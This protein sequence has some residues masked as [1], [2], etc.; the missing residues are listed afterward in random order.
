MLI[1][2]NTDNN[3]EGGARMSAYFTQTLQEMFNR[4]DEQI[5]RLEVHLSDVN[6]GKEG[7]EDKRC[8]LEARLK[9][10]KPVVVTH[11]AESVEL[12]VNGAA[13]KLKKTLE[14]TIGRLR[15]H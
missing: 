4:F 6:A 3:I 7:G 13:E 14:N 5:M 15:N 1:Q 2:I 12:A 8:L 10:L 11:H 9:G